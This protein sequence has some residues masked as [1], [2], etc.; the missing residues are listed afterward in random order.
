MSS[1]CGSF[2]SDAFGVQDK[3][4]ELKSTISTEIRSSYG[5]VGN[6]KCS[7]SRLAS[8][9]KRTWLGIREVSCNRSH[10]LCQWPPLWKVRLQI[11]C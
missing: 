3:L 11:G 9:A 5:L 8:A 6:Q 10:R 1:Y 4:L 2:L 7:L